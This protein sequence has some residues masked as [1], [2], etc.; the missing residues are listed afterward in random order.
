M[1][2]RCEICGAREIYA[3]FRQ[4]LTY[5]CDIIETGNESWYFKTRE[6]LPQ[7]PPGG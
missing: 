7:I 4:W 5:H 6:I 1:T 2:I 3:H